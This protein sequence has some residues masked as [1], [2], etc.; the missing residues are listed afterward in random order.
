MYKR[1]LDNPNMHKEIYKLILGCIKAFVAQ[2]PWRCIFYPHIDI[3]VQIVFVPATQCR[4]RLVGEPG[5]RKSSAANAVDSF[6][7]FTC[8][9]IFTA[10]SLECSLVQV[11]A[12]VCYF[13]MPS[14]LQFPLLTF[15][16]AS[17]KNIIIA[18]IVIICSDFVHPRCSSAI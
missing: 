17:S 3:A 12:R 14:L 13:F 7:L 10:F 6:D 15:S 9:A 18:F 4:P 8:Y 1:Y 16:I 2:F 5:N 11:C